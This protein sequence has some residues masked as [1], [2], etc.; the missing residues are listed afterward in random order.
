M[1]RSPNFFSVACRAPNGELVSTV[2]AIEKTWIGR[3][4]WLKLPFLRGS[5]A[6]LDSMAL[7]TKAMRFAS[8]I[9]MAPEYQ[10]VEEGQAAAPPATAPNQRV[11]DAT[12]GGAMF[13]G[14][15]VGLLLFNYLPNLLAEQMTRYGVHSSILKN[16]VTE[17]LKI[18]IFIGYIYLIGRLPEI[19]EV[20]KYH[21]AE[22]KAINTLEADQEL[23]LDNCKAQTRLHPRC[24][25]SFAILVLIVSLLLFT[26]VPRYPIPSLE[27]HIIAS[28]SVRFLLE[29]AIL[30]LVAGVSYEA[31][32]L[33]GRFK[34]S[35]LV[36]T[37]FWPGLQS[38]YLTTREPDAGQIEVALAALKL[39]VDSEQERAKAQLAS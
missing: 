1:M 31:I 21:G 16:F 14:L 22:H 4:K 9:Q 37:L 39:V 28:T 12:V 7:G 19:T 11:Q 6:L 33:A 23:N 3:Q 34:S 10:K 8:N 18:I 5:L 29:I 35:A 17:I 20:F 2:E 24:G 25:T 26:F 13:I 32:R 15:A 27:G 36:N 30:P 38:Q